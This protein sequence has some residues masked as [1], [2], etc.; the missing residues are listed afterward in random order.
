MAYVSV[1]AGDLWRSR[2][3]GSEKMQLTSGPATVTLPVWSP[4]GTRLAYVTAEIGKPF[5]MMLISAQ[6]GTPEELLPGHNGVDFNWSPDG[7]QILF[8]H[9]PTLASAGIEV[10]DLKTRQT[11]LVPGSQG[12]FSPRRSPDGR[13]MVALTPDSTTLM[14]YDFHS[15]KWTKWLTEPG[16]IS[17]PTWSKDG[18]S[19]YFDNFLTGNPT[20]RRVPLGGTHAESLYSLSGLRRLQTTMSGTWSGT[21][22]DGSRLYVQDLSVQEVYA[23]DVEFP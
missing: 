9:G 23:L 10:L 11:T 16:N 22:P 14:L 18:R 1:P 15:Q 2:V 12:L 5:R 6:G 3:D 13:Y 17:Y 4:D 7:T 21:T 20:A 19:V 8:G